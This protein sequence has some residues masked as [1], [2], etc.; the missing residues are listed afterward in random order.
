MMKVSCFFVTGYNSEF[1]HIRSYRFIDTNR[2]FFFS[3]NGGQ[4][5]TE[6]SFADNT[7]KD[8]ILG[9]AHSSIVLQAEYISYELI[10]LKRRTKNETTL[11]CLVVTGK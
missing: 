2:E 7:N 4:L 10:S 8:S 3:K 9:I 6:M 1:F 11:L 5:A